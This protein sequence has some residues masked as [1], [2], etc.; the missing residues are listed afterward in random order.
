MGQS[1][2]WQWH[3]A[4]TEDWA[5][6]DVMDQRVH[7]LLCVSLW[8]TEA[9]PPRGL[10]WAFGRPELSSCPPCVSSC[11]SC[12]SL[13]PLATNSTSAKHSSVPAH[14][15]ALSPSELK[16]QLHNQTTL[17]STVSCY[18]ADQPE[19][20]G[21][22]GWQM[23]RDTGQVPISS[24]SSTCRFPWQ[25]WVLPNAEVD[26]FKKFWIIRGMVMPRIKA[27]WRGRIRESALQKQKRFSDDSRTVTLGSISCK[28]LLSLYSYPVATGSCEYSTNCMWIHTLPFLWL[29][30]GASNWDTW[31]GKGDKWMGGWK[32]QKDHLSSLHPLE[33][34]WTKQ[35]RQIVK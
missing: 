29:H 22:P 31:K 34:S 27:V 23:I 21:Q 18:G 24:G 26:P 35:L 11:R 12:I 10:F 32:S 28:N 16:G 33:E 13:D 30:Q 6:F 3:Q 1:L 4:G 7:P 14:R 25:V 20:A 17:M 2:P 8:I 9:T 19:H 5:F 15:H